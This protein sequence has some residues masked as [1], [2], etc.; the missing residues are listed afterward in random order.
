MNNTEFFPYHNKHIKFRN[1]A[2]QKDF[3]GVIFDMPW[4]EKNGIS[5]NYYFIPTENLANFK[6]LESD[7]EKQSEYKQIID[8]KDI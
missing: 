7:K 8:I 6:A 2:L 1:T 4:E 3:S 5:T